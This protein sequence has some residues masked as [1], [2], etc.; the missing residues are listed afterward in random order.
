MINCLVISTLPAEL[1]WALIGLA[2]TITGT[3]VEAFIAV[4]LWIADD[5]HV[6]VQ[7]YALGMTCQIGGV[8][9]AGCMGGS[10]AGI[11]SQM[12]YLT[13]G[14]LGF[15]VFGGGSGV[16]YYKE[17]TFGYLLGFLPGAWVCGWLAFQASPK[18]ES[19]T[20]SGLCGLAVIHGVGVVY[21]IAGYL[22]GWITQTSSLLVAVLSYSVQPLP[23]HLAIV[24]TIGIL[25]YALRK[26]MLY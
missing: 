24:C 25:S 21:L 12:A 17:P 5:T 16:E 8:L 3:F 23:G 1:L 22:L 13:L 19:L 11:L 2:L 7:N 18:I 20:F 4:P 6:V 9:L 10:R 26:L 15:Q 14:M